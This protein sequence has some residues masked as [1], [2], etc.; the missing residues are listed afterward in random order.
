MFNIPAITWTLT[1]VL[2]LS[3]SYHL[4]Q[5]TKPHQVTDR[6]NNILHALM[7]I[8]MAAMLWNLAPSTVLAQIAVLASAALWFIIQAVARPEYKLLCA[9]RPGRLKCLYHSLSMAGAAVMIA[10]MAQA[11]TGPAPAQAMSMPNAHHS[12]TG[13]PHTA[14]LGTATTAAGLGHAPAILLTIVFAAAAT[15]FLI[16][17]LH[18]HTANTHDTTSRQ[19]ATR[20][21]HGLEGLGAASMAFMFATLIP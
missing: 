6:I 2:L 10:M 17:L 15:T 8:L 7:N 9:G 5:A 11:T 13:A 14:T 4:L 12:M 1:A 3:G 20:T 18:R 16:L 19:R 21:G